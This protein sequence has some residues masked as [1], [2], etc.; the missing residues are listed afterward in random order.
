MITPPA[1][2]N[3]QIPTRQSTVTHK[4]H[5]QYLL[6][7]LVGCETNYEPKN[8]GIL[9]PRTIDGP[10]G[11]VA[12]AKDTKHIRTQTLINPE[13]K[14]EISGELK[15]HL[16]ISPSGGRALAIDIVDFQGIFSL[17]LSFYASAR[18][19]HADSSPIC[20]TIGLNRA[21]YEEKK[22]QF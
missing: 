3:S 10:M 17:S 14:R 9:R 22:R 4:H 20:T 7:N 16:D 19:I 21:K 1:L 13:S 5:R 8:P 18:T 6:E 2:H 12:E 11:I 15:I